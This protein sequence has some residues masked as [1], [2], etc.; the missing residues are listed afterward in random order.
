MRWKFRTKGNNI[1]IRVWRN[2]PYKGLYCSN[3]VQLIFTNTIKTISL[4]IEIPIEENEKRNSQFTNIIYVVSIKA[5]LSTV[6][7][8]RVMGALG[9]LT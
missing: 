5:T 9:K 2:D 4:I 6:M 8:P 3:D 1:F 7:K